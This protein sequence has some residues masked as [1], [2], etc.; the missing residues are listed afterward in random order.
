MKGKVRIAPSVSSSRPSLL[1][2]FA[3]AKEPRRL[4]SAGERTS[5]PLSQSCEA[6]TS[7]EVGAVEAFELVAAASSEPWLLLLAARPSSSNPHLS[8][9]AV[10]AAWRGCES[11]SGDR[12]RAVSVGGCCAPSSML[13]RRDVLGDAT[14]AARELCRLPRPS[15]VRDEDADPGVEDPVAVES[16]E[17][18][19]SFLPGWSRVVRLT[20]SLLLPLLLARA[21][22]PAASEPADEDRVGVEVSVPC[23]GLPA[24]AGAGA[25]PG[26]ADCVG[27]AA[28]GGTGPECAVVVA[29][30]GPASPAGA[31]GPSAGVA[32]AMGRST[33]KRSAAGSTYEN[34][35]TPG[36][37]S[38]VVAVA[39]DVDSA[40]LA[41]STVEVRCFDRVS[42]WS[43]ASCA[44]LSSS[45]RS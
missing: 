19:L 42:P 32:G 12:K 11:M 15:S 10:S 1:S 16:S 4:R 27:M 9:T 36:L 3:S 8:R 22:P 21:S 35:S 17:R 30:E 26:S 14:D 29:V 43:C 45:R 33:T 39:V 7:G 24:C 37:P 41:I 34:D 23:G 25:C 2:C 28:A 20:E 31:A 6:R 44:A 5:S 18:R 38:A 13:A 40:A